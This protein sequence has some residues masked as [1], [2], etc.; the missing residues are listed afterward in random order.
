ML[1]PVKRRC[2]SSGAPRE[3]TGNRRRQRAHRRPSRERRKAAPHTRAPGADQIDPQTGDADPADAHRSERGSPAAAA[4][5][6]RVKRVG[7]ARAMIATAPRS[8]T[9][10]TVVRNSLSEAGARLP[11]S[12]RTP[13]AKAI[14]VA[15]GIAQPRCEPGIGAGDAEKDQR[16]HRS[17]RTPRRS[18]GRRRRPRSRGA[19]EELALDLQADEQEEKRHQ[20]VVDPQVHGQRPGRRRPSHTS[21]W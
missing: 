5:A 2:G 9:I 1:E 8:S 21:K 18:S 7:V 14:S 17:C 12:A 19:V 4:S 13:I 10:A 3:P 11:S 15:A 16:R 6:V 20:P